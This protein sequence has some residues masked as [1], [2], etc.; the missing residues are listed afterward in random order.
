MNHHSYQAMPAA[1]APVLPIA[2]SPIVSQAGHKRK[3]ASNSALSI[4]SSSNSSKSIPLPRQ[5]SAPA[6]IAPVTEAR[7]L[8]VP[9]PSEFWK[10]LLQEWNI[11]IL[12]T[13]GIEQDDNPNNP[14]KKVAFLETSPDRVEAYQNIELLTAVRRRDLVTLRKIAALKKSTNSTMN[15][16]NRFGESILHLACRKGSLDVVQLLVGEECDCSLL[17]QDDY[18]RT[19]LHDACWTVSPPWELLKLILKKAPVLWRVSDVRGHL[20]LQYVPK[21]AWPQWQAFLSK[22]KHLLQRIMVLSYHNIDILQ[23][24]QPSQAVPVVQSPQVV[25]STN[26]APL[27]VP[28][29]TLPQHAAAT[30]PQQQQVTPSQ[31]PMPQPA[32]HPTVIPSSAVTA[33]SAQGILARALSQS[34]P[35]M[36][37]AISQ[38]QTQQPT[39]QGLTVFKTEENA[40]VQQQAPIVQGPATAALDEALRA[41]SEH[42]S[43]ART[44]NLLLTEAAAAPNP[45]K[46]STSSN[47][48]VEGSAVAV[49]TEQVDPK[50]ESEAT[51]LPYAPSIS[52]IA[53][54][55][56]G[57]KKTAG[58]IAEAAQAAPQA[59]SQIAAEVAAEVAAEANPLPAVP[60]PLGHVQ[61][62]EQQQ[63]QQ[64]GFQPV[65]EKAASTE[66]PL[67]SNPPVPNPMEVVQDNDAAMTA[68]NN[69]NPAAANN[70]VSSVTHSAS[71]SALEETG[72]E[73]TT[74]SAA[75]TLT[76]NAGTTSNSS[77]PSE[78]EAPMDIS[79]EDKGVT[80]ATIDP[81][82]Q[83]KSGQDQSK[84]RVVG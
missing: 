40:S 38:P 50:N 22:N 33:Q 60:N 69:S 84:K 32:N 46:E 68:P 19:V 42:R 81:A 74:N 64:Q 76:D 53:A 9:K 36:V 5:N 4:S 6:T 63:Q 23:H 37:K 27:G 24:Q 73:T 14:D 75:T 28:S 16:C 78:P 35:A 17:V 45:H 29:P 41:Q 79:N 55:L 7:P 34:S 58:E 77:F 56:A 3:L 47:I 51:P 67:G 21:S 65:H 10:S 54:R 25:M 1:A 31:A 83:D 52:M 18:G 61:Q 57:Q 15:A 39:Q 11:P 49:K 82:D 59:A 8:P 66:N 62:E 43:K 80:N 26:D 48:A 20:A 44:S 72:S 13:V 30:T 70:S 2:P 12:D 71:P